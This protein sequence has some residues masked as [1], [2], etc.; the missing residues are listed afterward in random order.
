MSYQLSQ[1]EVQ[2]LLEIKSPTGVE[3]F[4]Q[5]LER[6]ANW[7]WCPLGGRPAN[8]ANVETTAEPGPGIVERIVNAIDAM[9]E[10]AYLSNGRSEA[11]ASPRS[12]AERYFGLSGGTFAFLDKDR[13]L[14]NSLAPNIKVE[15]RESGIRNTLSVSVLD[16]GIGQ[17]PKDLPSTILSLG[18]SNKIS[19]H[20]VCGAYGQGGSSTFAW[21]PYSIVVSRRKKELTDSRPDLVGWT[22]IR[23]HD[24]ISMKQNTYQYLVTNENEIPTFSPELLEGTRLEFGTYIIH[25]AYQAE[26]LV[27][28][29]SLVGYRYLNNYIFDPVFPYTIRDTREPRP[30][31]RYMYGT[32]GRL[33]DASVIYKREDEVLFGT[34]GAIKVRYWVFQPR[35]SQEVSEGQDSVKLDS[36]LESSGSNRTV[37][38]TLNGQKHAYL[39]KNFIKKVSR[40]SMVGDNL[41]VQVDCDR[42]S[43][44]RKKE[45]FTSN[46]SGVRSGEGRM[47]LIEAAITQ[48]LED[49]ELRRINSQL[50][51][52]HYSRVDEEEERKIIKIL[53]K[54]IDITRPDQAAG[55]PP[56][57]GQS[58]SGRGPERFR[59]N[60]PPTYFEFADLRRPLHIEP[61]NTTYIDIKT[62]GPNNMFTRERHRAALSLE[63]TGGQDIT[64]V[65]GRLNN[66]RLQIMVAANQNSS[67]DTR[68]TLRAALQMD[69]GVYI[70]TE[71]PCMIVPPP[72]PY[73]GVDPPTFLK[74]AAKGDK[75]QLKKGKTSRVLLRSDCQ[76]DF[77]SRPERF[78]QFQFD[79][80]LPGISLTGWKHPFSGEMELKIKA[81]DSCEVGREGNISVRFIIPD[82][83]ILEDTKSCVIAEPPE[84]ETRSG[85]QQARAG[86]FKVLKVWRT[87]PPDDP[88]ALVWN[89]EG[90]NWNE[91]NVGKYAID[92]DAAG[93]DLLLLY[94]NMDHIELDRERRRR[95][96][97]HGASREKNFERRYAAYIG[98]HLWLCCEQSESLSTQTSR[99]EQGVLEHPEEGL[100]PESQEQERAIEKEIRRV[101][102]TIIQTLRSESDLLL[103]EPMTDE[104]S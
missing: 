81:D 56:S 74:F 80:S 104:E 79:P 90:I 103:E 36:Y 49:P 78:G 13:S 39:T 45:M 48:A 7:N 95:L 75:I 35:R 59:P 72:P 89:S 84:D 17:H 93:N 82:G 33:A 94:V 86:N 62:D 14:L 9:L 27:A 11:P 34:D 61:G 68:Y 66:G 29:W 51:Q 52:D 20:Y 46:R 41:L 47:E 18:A 83:I 23:K 38:I 44:L 30:Q 16:K 64:M 42:L 100:R 31:D 57:Q 28:D 91:E 15:A 65:R 101:A 60:D 85:R 102:K 21:C 54:L 87:P 6:Q 58:Q 2:R 40:L 4:L 97:I 26:R 55:S 1:G 92:K 19:K 69:G 22:I 77:L 24:D 70:V 12:A 3:E 73:L 43:Q 99:G 37:V 96:Q 53:Q 98:Y 67:P 10:L 63:T 88:D 76:N 50:I 8:A 32:L 25:I 71:R 5:S